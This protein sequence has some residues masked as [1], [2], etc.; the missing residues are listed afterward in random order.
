VI[1]RPIRRARRRR[2]AVALLLLLPVVGLL[3]ASAI[4]AGYSYRLTNP[5]EYAP[6]GPRAGTTT[7]AQPAYR[8]RNPRAAHGLAFRDVELPTTGGA[9]LRGWLVP[10]PPGS[11]LAIVAAHARAGD[12]RD[13]LDELP[14][15]H[16]LGATALLFD[17][18]EHGASDGAGR[19]MGLGWREGEDVAAA[20]RYLKETAGARRVVVVGHSLGGTAAILAAAREPAIDAVLA[21]SAI[22]SFEAYVHGL[23][24]AWLERRRLDRAL[25]PRPRAWSEAVVRFTAWRLGVG[26][27]PAAEEVVGRIA[28]RPLLL[29]HGAADDIVPPSHAERLYSRAGAGRALWLPPAAGHNEAFE[30]HPDEYAAR[31]AELLERARL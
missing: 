12:R 28:P 6:F 31:L 26:D 24:E 8:A 11:D 30:T 15:Y 4:V 20:A 13:Y 25:P 23:G 14:L 16:R 10:G 2:A 27:A 3:G 5:P 21:E 18:R 9:T 7:D 29:V 19:G 1:A 17:Y 22:A